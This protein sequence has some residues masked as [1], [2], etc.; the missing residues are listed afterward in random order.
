MFI[1]EDKINATKYMH[2]F[3]HIAFDT[4]WF[5]TG[6]IKSTKWQKGRVGSKKEKFKLQHKLDEIIVSP[7]II[8]SVDII[9]LTNSFPDSLN[10]L[11]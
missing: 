8:E 7:S 9:R 1:H 10:I 6:F 11:G 3:N 2:I 5:R 4:S